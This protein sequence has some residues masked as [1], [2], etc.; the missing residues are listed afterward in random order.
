MASYWLINAK[1]NLYNLLLSKGED[2]LTSEELEIA[3]ALSKDKD[4]QKILQ[5][6][7]D[8]EKAERCNR[9]KNGKNPV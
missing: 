7:V 1:R 8:K 2:N 4:I 3:Y 5:E 9:C 6:A